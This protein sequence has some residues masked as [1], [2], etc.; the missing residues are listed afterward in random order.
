MPPYRIYHADIY[1]SIQSGIGDYKTL[2]I[3]S[4][5]DGIVAFLLSVKYGIG[6]MFSFIPVLL[7]QGSISI[8]SGVF[9]DYL[10]AQTNFITQLSAIGGVFVM[11]IGLNL[12]EIKKIKIA[13]MLPAI[14]GAC[15]YLI[16]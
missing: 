10:I 3:K 1:G 14:F 13:N 4:V 7:I 2:L 12:L 5:L 15:Y 16:F 11:M 8:L 6:V 9:G